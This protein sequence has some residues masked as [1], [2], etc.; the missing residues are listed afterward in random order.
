MLSRLHSLSVAQYTHQSVQ[1]KNGSGNSIMRASTFLTCAVVLMGL[2]SLLRAQVGALQVAQGYNGNTLSIPQS[3]KPA[4]TLQVTGTSSR[5]TL[6]ANRA[7][8][9][10]V[11]KLVFDQAEKQFVIEGNI[12]GTVTLRLNEQ[13]LGVVLPAICRQAFLKFRFD[14]VNGIFTIER[15]EASVRAAF[16]QLRSLDAELRNQLRLMGLTVPGDS[17]VLNSSMRTFRFGGGQEGALARGGLGG[18]ASPELK[19]TNEPNQR[20]RGHSD[21]A[22]SLAKP[23]PSKGET[24]TAGTAQNGLLFD[25]E[26]NDSYEQFLRQN[27]FVSF[28]IPKDKPEPVFS[29]LQLWSKQANIPILVDPSVPRGSK[30]VIR[31]TIPPRPIMDALNSIAPYARL[32]WRW[33][34]NSI[35]ITTTPE[36][37]MLLHDVSVVKAGAP[38]S[39]R[40]NLRS[41]SEPEV[42]KKADDQKEKPAPGKS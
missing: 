41:K 11:L 12:S 33:A 8:V 4:G 36:F 35:F 34:G 21:K 17:V 9:L 42:E 39:Q 10:D 23:A 18:S 16:S 2:P 22:N 14:A 24:G 40:G 31:G 5:F 28:N 1:G 3:G 29:I 38:L 26:Y 19:S 13:P 32:D 25:L 7:D 15:D 6:S 30:F 37:E 27:N 20:N